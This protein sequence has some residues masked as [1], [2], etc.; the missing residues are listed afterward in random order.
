MTRAESESI[1]IFTTAA[2]YA[3]PEYEPDEIETLSTLDGDVLLHKSWLPSRTTLGVSASRVPTAAEFAAVDKP[4]AF[5]IRGIQRDLE[6][7]RNHPALSEIARFIGIHTARSV[8]DG[9]EEVY[10]TYPGADY[11]NERRNTANALLP[12]ARQLPPVDKIAGGIFP[13][14]KFTESISRG[15]LP[16]SSGRPVTRYSRSASSAHL[17]PHD[18][19]HVVAWLGSSPVFRQAA[20]EVA[21]G[22]SDFT[23]QVQAE[24]LD[25]AIT[26]EVIG[27]AAQ[28]GSLDSLP[29]IDKN[30]FLFARGEHP[31]DTED[32]I[33]GFSDTAEHVAAI[34]KVL[35]TLYER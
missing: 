5:N 33:A 20:A 2:G 21:G 12:A 29:L 9:Y 15:T 24:S 26:P 1:D 10:I 4:A 31:D 22:G 32:Y 6:D 30:A 18:A 16:M 3:L 25:L 7:A 11:V 19:Y 14:E 8:I 23:V 35:R 13:V 34:N 17:P 27:L 28:G